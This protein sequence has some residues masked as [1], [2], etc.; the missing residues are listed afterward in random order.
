MF[1]ELDYDCFLN[2]TK[3]SPINQTQIHLIEYFSHSVYKTSITVDWRNRDGEEA[4]QNNR[5]LYTGQI[6][7]FVLCV[8]CI[9]P[10]YL[11]N[12]WSNRVKNFIS[13]Y[14][15]AQRYSISRD[16]GSKSPKNS[17]TLHDGHFKVERKCFG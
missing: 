12:A 4:V 3:I 13:L 8:S 6:Y 10:R 11:P 7:I 1:N 16:I 5:Y 9:L 14:F 17:K 2:D 15:S